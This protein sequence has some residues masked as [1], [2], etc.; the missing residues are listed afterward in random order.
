MINRCHSAKMN[1]S[2]HTNKTNNRVPST[3]LTFVTQKRDIRKVAVTMKRVN[4]SLCLWRNLNSSISPVITDSIP[5][6]CNKR[7][8]IRRKT[9]SQ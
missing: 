4:S 9:E 5:P 8:K 7:N 2:N 3:I 1:I 6:I